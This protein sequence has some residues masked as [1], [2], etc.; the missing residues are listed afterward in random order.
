MLDVAP[1]EELTDDAKA[2]KRYREP[3]DIPRFWLVVG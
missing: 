2:L 3:N 1:T